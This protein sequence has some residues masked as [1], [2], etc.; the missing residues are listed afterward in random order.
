VSYP[1]V[2][3]MVREIA[4][5]VTSYMPSGCLVSPHWRVQGDP[6]PVVTYDLI[7]AE[8]WN[9]IATGGVDAA[10]LTMTFS[11]VAATVASAVEI[12]DLVRWALITP[13]AG[14]T[15][16]FMATT[17]SYRTSDVT[18]DDGTG[19]R[20]RTVVVTAT[21]QAQDKNTNPAPIQA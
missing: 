1:A 15:V 6:M 21:I 19:D 12:A 18:P 8:W 13:T 11:C 9:T 14:G 2:K 3:N 5:Q 4:N 20:E 7:S 10:T 17:V 16:A